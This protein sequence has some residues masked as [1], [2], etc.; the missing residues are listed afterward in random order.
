MIGEA[1]V[2]LVEDHAC[3]TNK[4]ILTPQRLVSFHCVLHVTVMKFI[5]PRQS[6]RNDARPAR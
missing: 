5:P 3:L 1:H 2:G 4:L 6:H